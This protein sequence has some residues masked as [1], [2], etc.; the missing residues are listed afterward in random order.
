MSH[1]IACVGCRAKYRV[2][3]AHIG[4]EVT[5]PKCD[6]RFTVPG[7]PKATQPSPPPPPPLPPPP[8]PPPPPPLPLAPK[9]TANQKALFPIATSIMGI[10]AG[11][12]VG[13]FAAHHFPFFGGL[14]LLGTPYSPARY[15]LVPGHML[16]CSVILGAAGCGLGIALRES[17]TVGTPD[18]PVRAII[19]T[20]IFIAFL[21]GGAV[22]AFMF[23]S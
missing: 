5:C 1:T 9:V 21:A 10:V 11:C 15:A 19:D 3:D 13:Y 6:A 14:A 4:C 12:V 17:C 8:P 18:F 7:P 16:L 2:T 20:S 23:F 22:A